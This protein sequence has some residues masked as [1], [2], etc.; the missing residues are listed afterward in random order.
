MARRP[1]CAYCK[2]AFT[3]RKRGRPPKY[4]CAAHRQRAYVL[5]LRQ[6]QIPFLLLG[7]DIDN[8]KTKA[9]IERAIIDVLRR[10]GIL[11]AE[12]PKAPLLRSLTLIG[13]DPPWLMGM[14]PP[15]GRWSA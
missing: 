2:K 11:P 13:I 3:P 12:P 8:M 1:R 4:C 6:E 14:E 15:C 10:L 5:C 9:G 7:R